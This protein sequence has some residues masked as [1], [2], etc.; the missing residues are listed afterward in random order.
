MIHVIGFSNGTLQ[1]WNFNTR[2]ASY[3]IGIWHRIIC[4]V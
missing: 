1:L 4:V 2:Y 3:V